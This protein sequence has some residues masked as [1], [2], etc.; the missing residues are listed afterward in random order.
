MIMIDTDIIIWI[1]RENKEIKEKFIATIIRTKGYLFLTPIQIAELYTGVKEK[2]RAKIEKFIDSFNIIDIDRKIGKLAG[3][4][5]NK[6]GKSHNVTIADAI[7]GASTKIHELKLWTLNKKHY[8]M[9]EKSE[10]YQ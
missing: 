6:Y 2:E 8:P 7:I 4:F 1:L 10:F 3:E 9:F 5:I